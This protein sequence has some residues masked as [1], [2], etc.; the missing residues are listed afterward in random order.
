MFCDGQ[1]ILLLSFDVL[2]AISLDL[3]NITATSFRYFMSIIRSCLAL[4]DPYTITCSFLSP[5]SLFFVTHPSLL[6]KIVCVCVYHRCYVTLLSVQTADLSIV[7][8]ILLYS[9]I[10]LLVSVS[11]PV[12][13]R[14][15]MT[16]LIMK[17]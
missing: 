5:P 2:T 10:P 8:G 12:A 17:K 14:S 4:H 7:Y 15:F 6:D 3:L 1:Q 11:C 16:D 13:S 9:I